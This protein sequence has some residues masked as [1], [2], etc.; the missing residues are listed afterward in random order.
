MEEMRKNGA[1]LGGEESG[2]IIF[3]QHHTTGDGLLSALQ[4]LRAVKSSGRP[5]ADLAKLMT[6]FP[7][8]MINVKVKEKPEINSVPEFSRIIGQVEKKLEDKGRVLV[9]YSGTEPLC[10]VMVEGENRQTIQSYAKEIAGVIEK[11]LG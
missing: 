11:H 4:L 2:H 10:R 9:R 6:L 7:Q 8:V 3:S 5:L 1:V